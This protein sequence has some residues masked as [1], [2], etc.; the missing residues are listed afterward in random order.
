[1]TSFN[2]CFWM[3][4][5]TIRSILIGLFYPS[6]GQAIGAHLWDH[7]WKDYWEKAS[8]SAGTGTK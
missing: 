5:L 7:A 4:H 1:M 6:A 3:R 8:L 2:R